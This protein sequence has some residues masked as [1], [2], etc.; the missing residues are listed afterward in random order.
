MKLINRGDDPQVYILADTVDQGTNF[1]AWTYRIEL[2]ELGCDYSETL[3]LAPDHRYFIRLY[4]ENSAGHW[5]GKE[6]IVRTQPKKS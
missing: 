1:Y 5:T 3:G 6:F 2:G 4:A